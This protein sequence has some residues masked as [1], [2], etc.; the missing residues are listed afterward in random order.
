MKQKICS[1]LG[2]MS[3][4]FPFFMT[5][6]ACSE[7]P[8]TQNPAEVMIW[9]S[10]VPGPHSVGYRVMHEF[11]PTRTFRRKVEYFGKLTLGPIA[12]PLQI[13][14]WYPAERS[15][16][17]RRMRLEEYYQAMATETELAMPTS[18]Q[19]KIV[20]NR[21]RR[22]AFASPAIRLVFWG[23]G[24]TTIWNSSAYCQTGLRLASSMA[25]W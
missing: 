17:P 11:H 23:S 15:A 2:T 1:V 7:S 21:L 14:I 19:A 13:S 22:S 9:P 10:T 16:G 6:Q 8:K 4:L 25:I 24:I 5:A 3:I 12:R 20:L 18:D